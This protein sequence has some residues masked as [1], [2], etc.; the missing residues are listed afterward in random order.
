MV[1]S[2]WRPLAVARGGSFMLAL[3]LQRY[4]RHLAERQRWP[5]TQAMRCRSET[6]ETKRCAVGQTLTMRCRF[7]TTGD[8]QR[9]VKSGRCSFRHRITRLNVNGNRQQPRAQVYD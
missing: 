5:Q 6:T 8:R 1:T 9:I 2:A 7:A 4:L 3:G